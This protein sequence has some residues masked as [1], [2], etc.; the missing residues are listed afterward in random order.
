MNRDSLRVLMVTP[1]YFPFMGGIET[2]VHEVGRRLAQNGMHVTL[3]TTAPPQT[4]GTPPKEETVEGMRIIRVSAWPSQSDYYIAPEIYSIITRGKWDLVHCQ[5]CHTFVPPLAMFAA[6]AAKIP[7][8]LTFHS[9]GNSSRV[10]NKLRGI[11]WRLMQ[12][13]LSQASRLIGVSSV[14]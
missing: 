4:L 7:Y 8:I 9:A 13:L 5:G 1:R 3:L 6:R 11:Q 2:H 14:D 10:R 12:P